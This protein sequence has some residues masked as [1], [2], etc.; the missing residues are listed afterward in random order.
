[1]FRLFTEMSQVI[2]V[3]I[4]VGKRSDSAAVHDFVI[5]LFQLGLVPGLFV[6]K[7]GKQVL[8]WARVGCL[9]QFAVLFHRGLFATQSVL[10]YRII[11]RIGYSIFIN[12]DQIIAFVF[13]FVDK[14]SKIPS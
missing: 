2:R 14:T 12:R 1:M 9:G 5:H 7:K 11:W 10:Q 3:G 6:G 4:R 13:P 8:D